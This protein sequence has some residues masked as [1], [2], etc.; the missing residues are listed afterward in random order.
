MGCVLVNFYLNEGTSIFFFFFKEWMT[1]TYIEHREH[2]GENYLYI[3]AKRET[4]QW[5]LKFIEA[6]GAS[7]VMS[8][9]KSLWEFRPEESEEVLQAEV[10]LTAK[11]WDRKSLGKWEKPSMDRTSN[12]Y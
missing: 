2:G 9:R 1:W 8:K 5:G 10:A 7:E 4:S 11:V 3:Q 6:Q 12:E